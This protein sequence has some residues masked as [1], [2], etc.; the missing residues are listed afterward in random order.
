MNRRE[1]ITLALWYRNPKNFV[2]RLRSTVRETIRN[3]YNGSYVERNDVIDEVCLREG[4]VQTAS[5][6]LHGRCPWDS[7]WR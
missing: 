4:F 6:Y 5:S 1:R 7:L 3:I 2:R